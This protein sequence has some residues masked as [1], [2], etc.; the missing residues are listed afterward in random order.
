M[1]NGTGYEQRGRGK[2]IH[3]TCIWFITVCKFLKNRYSAFPK[4]TENLLE[5]SNEDK[6]RVAKENQSH[7]QSWFEK[8]TLRRKTGLWWWYFLFLTALQQILPPIRLI[9][10]IQRALIK[11][12]ICAKHRAEGLKDIISFHPFA[13]LPNRIYCCIEEERSKEPQPFHSSQK[14]CGC[15]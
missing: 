14:N 9:H 3:K 6:R 4:L 1:I 11:H 12:L 5:K 15:P 13:N 7:L 2:I 10:S 8:E